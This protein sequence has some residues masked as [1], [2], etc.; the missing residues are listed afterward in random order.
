MQ[1]RDYV[2]VFC[3]LALGKPC[4]SC[5]ILMRAVFWI[6]YSPSFSVLFP[7][8]PKQGFMTMKSSLCASVVQETISQVPLCSDPMCHSDTLKVGLNFKSNQ[9]YFSQSSEEMNLK[10]QESPH[11]LNELQHVDINLLI[12]IVLFKN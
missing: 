4:N 2:S 12:C 7:Q 10:S 11:R 9:P 8:A 1:C 6:Q 5:T 3:K